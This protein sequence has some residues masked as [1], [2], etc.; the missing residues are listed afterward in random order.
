MCESIRMQ[1]HLLHMRYLV[2]KQAIVKALREA[3]TEMSDYTKAVGEMVARV[4]QGP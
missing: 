3:H 4:R 2:Y 1:P